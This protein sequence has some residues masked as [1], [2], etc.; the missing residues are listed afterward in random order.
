[1][2]FKLTAKTKFMKNGEE[3]K[4]PK[5]NVG[6]QLSIE[7]P[8]DSNGYMTAVNVY[9]EKAAGAGT[10]TATAEKKDDGAVDTWKDAPKD[11]ASPGSAASPPPATEMTGPPAKPDA[12]DPGPPTL[13]RGKPSDQGRLHVPDLENEAPPAQKEPAQTASNA[14]P[15]PVRL[16]R[17]DDD[18]IP[19]SAVQGDDLIRKATDAAF[20]FTQ[21]LPNYVCKEMMARY[22]SEATPPQWQPLD[23]VS[24][25]V[26]YENGKEDYRNLAI[27]GKAVNKKIDELNGSWSTGEFGTILIDLFSPATAAD[28][29]YKGMSRSA[30]IPAKLYDFNVTHDHSH[31][32]IH[33]GSQNYSPAYRG[34][35][36][37]DPATA[38]VLR[39]EMQAYGFPSTFPTDH[40][41]SATDYEY[42]RLGD[43]H[44]YLLPVHS[45]TLSCDRASPACSRNAIDFRNYH[46]YEGE[47]TIQFGDD[48]K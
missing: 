31:W 5:F 16:P 24:A 46:K 47:S 32:D 14:D 44:Q 28:F 1:M 18:T 3:I 38:R 2:D 26:I 35:V 21:G 30:G 20:D 39:I 13:E 27:N 36:W 33:I 15:A 7:G 10:P 23:V 37:I 9:W 40:V 8:E 41:E 25:N 12:D 6:D 17:F 43:A 29:H 22:Q 42:I 45:E 4:D 11:T 48:K 34:S 19:R